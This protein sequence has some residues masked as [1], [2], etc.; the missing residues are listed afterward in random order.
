MA[1]QLPLMY[2]TSQP[3]HLKHEKDYKILV[4]R[5]LI[6]AMNGLV[7]AFLQMYLPLTVYYTLSASTLIFT[8]LLNFWLYKIELTSSQIKSIIVALVGILLVIN[9]RVVY[10][11]IDGGY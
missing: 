6:S 8:F 2:F 3:L 5:G 4:I 9:G 7:A 1:I 10:T 11:M